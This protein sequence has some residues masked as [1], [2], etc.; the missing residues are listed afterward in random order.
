[1]CYLAKRSTTHIQRDFNMLWQKPGE[2]AREY[3]LRIDKLDMELYQS[4]IEGKEQSSEYRK[5]ILDTIQELALENFQL[6]LRE[7]IH[8]AISELR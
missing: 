8:C 2:S 4:M 1:M 7:D 3:G 5:A 6:R